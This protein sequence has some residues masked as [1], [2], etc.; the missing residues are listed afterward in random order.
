VVADDSFLTQSGT[1]LGTPAYMAPE[2]ASAAAGPLTTAA[3]IYSL[4]AILYHLLTRRPP[5]QAATA[6]E[7]MRQAVELEPLPP[8]RVEPLV[9][10]DLATI[11]LK[12]LHK[13]PARR[14][15]SARAFAQDLENWRQGD[16]IMARP[17]T[18]VEVV[19]RWCRRQPALAASLFT[20]VVLLLTVLV[21]SVFSAVHIERARKTAVA[22]QQKAVAQLW[23]SY[24]D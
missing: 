8:E 11:C 23:Q 5:F 3:D 22:S 19:A 10:R 6:L 2:Q 20:V 17:A 14:Y 13:E 15:T 4:G 18:R 24:L 12:C 9:D 16:T 21:I 1:V 7:T